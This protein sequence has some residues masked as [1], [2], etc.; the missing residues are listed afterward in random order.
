MQTALNIVWRWCTRNGLSVNPQKTVLVPFTRRRKLELNRLFLGDE[1]IELQDQVKYLG[2]I[3]DSKLTF[4]LHVEKTIAKATNCFMAC[5][6]IMCRKWGM[7]PK[8]VLWIYT[9]VI[10]PMILYAA[11]VWWPRTKLATTQASLRKLQR[12]ACLAVT[13]AMRSTPTVAM[14]AL[15][16]LPPL[17][18]QVQR[19]AMLASSKIVREEHLLPGDLT[20]HL[21][22][23]QRLV[24]YTDSDRLSDV[25]SPMVNFEHPFEVDIVERQY[26]RSPS[27]RLADA[28]VFF[29]DGSKSNVGVGAGVYGPSCEIYEPM[30][31]TPT[32]FQAEIYAIELCAR[33]C[34]AMSELAGQTI[35]ILSDSQAAL[36]ALSSR[37]IKS[38]L[39][40]DCFAALK[41]LAD[42]CWLTLEWV[43]GHT[44][45]L[46][47]ER[48]DALAKAGA[49]LTYTGPEPFCGLGD[50]LK[51]RLRDWI[52]VEKAGNLN[53]LPAASI[54]RTFIRYN[55]D[56]TEYLLRLSRSDLRLLT[57][58][59]TGHCTLR[60]FL[61]K[62]GRS[63][64]SSCRFCGVA[65]ET[66]SHI[67]CDCWAVART[68]LKHVGYGFMPVDMLKSV[69]P[70]NILAFLKEVLRI[71]AF[72]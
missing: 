56:S 21:S 37:T 10:R 70:K 30:G 66:S 54:S 27:E 16:D 51:L 25:M 7:R 57:Q 4:G 46:G 42:K 38:R 31:S 36:R 44:G 6:S 1:Q 5:R 35:Y 72:A 2:V 61:N 49:N 50:T 18:I 26:W 17:H 22:I 69:P 29:T 12:L 52:A 62:I 14:E 39:V 53:S 33:H 58:M 34:L 9:A 3:L 47:N 60:Y 11:L 8:M 43:P 45:V 13:G 71:H 48:A 41:A 67:L 64:I 32:V 28:L 19:E 59:L 55:S 20:G 15:L 40:L 65:D 24:H 63:D 23:Y 68:R